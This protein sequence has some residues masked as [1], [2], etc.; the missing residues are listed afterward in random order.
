MADDRMVDP[1]GPVGNLQ[2]PNVLVRLVELIKYGHLEAVKRHVEQHPSLIKAADAQGV[3]PIHHAA[4]YGH[5][6]IVKWLVET[7][8]SLIKAADANGHQPIHFASDC[9]QFEV[10]QWLVATDPLL[11]AAETRKR[12]RA[13]E[14]AKREKRLREELDAK[15]QKVL[16]AI[17]SLVRGAGTTAVTPDTVPACKPGSLKYFA[18]LPSPA[19]K[20]EHDGADTTLVVGQLDDLSEICAFQSPRSEER[21]IGSGNLRISCGEPTYEDMMMVFELSMRLHEPPEQHGVPTHAGRYF[22]LEISTVVFNGLTG[23]PS[24]PMMPDGTDKDGNGAKT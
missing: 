6:D 7:D 2:D 11:F 14:D 24:W 12:R 4:Q 15:K 23:Y 5:L 8:A 19:L 1:V 3:Q 18:S 9:G 16:D 10:V 20:L 22:E 21:A 17:A 13:E